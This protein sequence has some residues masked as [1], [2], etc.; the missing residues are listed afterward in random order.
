[1]TKLLPEAEC[2]RAF[3]ASVAAVT[4]VAGAAAPTYGVR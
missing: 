1:M 3:R 2:F 4:E